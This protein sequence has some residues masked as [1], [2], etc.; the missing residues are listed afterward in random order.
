MKSLF[1]LS[2]ILS[3]NL[4][5]QELLFEGTNKE[6]KP[7]TVDFN[8]K[9]NSY[10]LQFDK[11][12]PIYFPANEPDKLVDLFVAVRNSTIEDKKQVDRLKRLGQHLMGSISKDVPFP[13]NEEIL[14]LALKNK[15]EAEAIMAQAPQENSKKKDCPEA[16]KKL[17][18]ELKKL[19]GKCACIVPLPPP[20]EE[21][22]KK[23]NAKPAYAL[24]IGEISPEKENSSFRGADISYQGVNDQPFHGGLDYLGVYTGEDRSGRTYGSEIDFK[25]DYDWGDLGLNY[26]TNLYVAPHGYTDSNGNQW[27]YYTTHPDKDN[28]RY[29]FQNA[30]EATTFEISGRY[31]PKGKAPL[32][33]T[34]RYGATYYGLTLG[35][36][37]HKDQ[38][39]NNWGGIAH[40]DLWHE[41]G[42][43]FGLEYI[44]H[45]KDRTDYTAEAKI[46]REDYFPVGSVAFCSKI[47]A[48]IQGSSSKRIA[49]DSKVELEFNT[50]KMG[51]AQKESPLFAARVWTN[52]WEPFNSPET[53]HNL[54]NGYGSPSAR[55][56]VTDS[57]M[58]SYGVGLETGGKN[59]RFS[60]EAIYENNSWSDKDL[61]YAFKMK[62][63]F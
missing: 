47:E 57:R 36:E 20:P 22:D 1:F 49:L 26:K 52:I 58:Q 45:M 27:F 51:G 2:L 6:G 24:V 43:A 9:V 15:E 62:Y 50:A 46:G 14:K 60:V 7:I 28:R 59:L 5:A 48:G 29:F 44:D 56:P 42:G 17:E 37:Q 3:A 16:Q 31:F 13:S 10:V 34:E 61:T 40:R 38:K 35:L 19:E 18:E 30:D 21:K 8:K 33:S 55:G 23:S 39:S 63:K 12:N 53:E 41:K 11:K 25:A 54:Y 32:N 4:Y